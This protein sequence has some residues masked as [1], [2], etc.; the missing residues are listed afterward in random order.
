MQH[1]ALSTHL[2][3]VW[4]FLRVGSHVNLEISIAGES[5]PANCAAVILRLF[6]PRVLA[7]MA[8]E[9]TLTGICLLAERAL[10]RSLPRVYPDVYYE[11]TI[12][13]EPLVTV[14]TLERSFI[15]VRSGVGLQLP[16]QGEP[17]ST[18]GTYM[19]LFPGVNLGVSVEQTFRFKSL[20]A[21][22]TDEGPL[23]A[24]GTHV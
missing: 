10:E 12:L 18:D 20:S 23:F 6:L 3:G 17:F 5:F 2:A 24:M 8:T 4:L 11:I 13:V 14:R 7:H 19:G 1:E 16:R 15:G 9:F 22:I 21:G